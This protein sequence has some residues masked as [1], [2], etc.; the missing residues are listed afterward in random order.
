MRLTELQSLKDAFHRG[1]GTAELDES[2][3]SRGDEL[4]MAGFH[5]CAASFWLWSFWVYKS[6]SQVWCDELP[7]HG[8]QVKGQP[9]T[10]LVAQKR[11]AAGRAI[12]ALNRIWTHPVECYFGMTRGT[13]NGETR[14][15]RFFAAQVK[16]VVIRMVMQ[17]LGFGQ[18]I[19]R[20]QQP[21]GCVL[22]PDTEHSVFLKASTQPGT[23]F[24]PIYSHVERLLAFLWDNRP[25]CG[26]CRPREL[27]Q[28]FR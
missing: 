28:M 18:Y 7:Y 12:C 3:G 15:D 6:L 24:G 8:E 27:V 1:V 4:A 5:F 21:A 20:F 16:A 19:R 25:H 10:D 9:T 13:L 2:S 14:W 11:C 17:R 26:G 23:E 22:S